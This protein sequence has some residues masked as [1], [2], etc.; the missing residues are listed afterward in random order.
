MAA[1]DFG[2]GIHL[3]NVIALNIKP[4]VYSEVL[5]SPGLKLSMYSKLVYASKFRSCRR[6]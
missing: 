3:E 2:L 5:I 4:G 1:N 6:K